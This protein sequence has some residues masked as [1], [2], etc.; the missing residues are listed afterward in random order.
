MTWR[1]NQNSAEAEATRPELVEEM[2]NA[3]ESVVVPT[4]PSVQLEADLKAAKAEAAEWQDRFLRKAAEFENFRKRA[5]KEKADSMFLAR[6]SVLIEFLPIADACERGMQ[7]I[8][9]GQNISGGL[10]QYQEGV[11]LL[12]KQLLDVLSRA[13][14]IPIKA[15]GK[16]FDPHLHE[17]LSREETIDFEEDTVVKELRRGYLFKDK[18][19]RPAQVIVAVHPKGTDK[20]S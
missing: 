5:E 7:S 4:D 1:T 15:E 12:Y 13:G 20:A 17:A 10:E 8:S 2:E 3:V 19:L 18:L 6:S 16:P 14:V 9:E 11:E